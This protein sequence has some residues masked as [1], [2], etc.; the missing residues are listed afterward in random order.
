[1]LSVI[2]AEV[3]VQQS[4]DSVVIR[5]EDGILVQQVMTINVQ[6]LNPIIAF[7]TLNQKAYLYLINHF[8][9]YFSKLRNHIVI[10]ANSLIM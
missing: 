8:F 6:K 2:G 10:I 4:Q 7:Y 5:Q 3:Q 1:M 9:I